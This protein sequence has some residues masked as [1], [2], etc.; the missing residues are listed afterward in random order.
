MTAIGNE[1][2]PGPGAASDR[3]QDF[4]FLA[5]YFERP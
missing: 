5:P 4:G 1:D 3:H 2:R